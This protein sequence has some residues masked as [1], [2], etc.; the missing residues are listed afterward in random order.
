MLN[1]GFRSVCIP[2]S[3]LYAV[4]RRSPAAWQKPKYDLR[5]GSQK[6]GFSLL[7]TD[8]VKNRVSLVN[9]PA[10]FPGIFKHCCGGRIPFESNK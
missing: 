5:T 6:P 3:V 4:G 2:A 1:G 9:L 8:S 10:Y 7:P